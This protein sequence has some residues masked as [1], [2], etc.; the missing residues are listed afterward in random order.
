VDA[1]DLS[2]S[3]TQGEINLKNVELKTTAF[4]DLQLPV[5]VKSGMV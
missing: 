4:D 5:T 2:I 1:K 3:V